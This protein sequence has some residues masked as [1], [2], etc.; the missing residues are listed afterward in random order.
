MS[1]SADNSMLASGSL[2]KTV[3]VWCLQTSAPVTVLTS[4]QSGITSV[5]VSPTKLGEGGED[6]G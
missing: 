6:E 4:H 2:D 5:Q 1:I 3:R